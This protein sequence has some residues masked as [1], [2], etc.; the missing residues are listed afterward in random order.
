[1]Q[2][3]WFY[4][5]LNFSRLVRQDHV[6]EDAN[7]SNDQRSPIKRTFAEAKQT[8]ADYEDV[9]GGN[10]YAEDTFLE[11]DEDESYDQQQYP[12]I[13]NYSASDSKVRY[14]EDGDDRPKPPPVNQTVRSAES[15][16]NDTLPEYSHPDESMRYGVDVRKQQQRTR[17]RRSRELFEIDV[18]VTSNEDEL[19]KRKPET[20]RS[21]SED[22]PTRTIKQ[23]VTR[24]TLSHPEKESQ[25]KS[26]SRRPT[27][28][29]SDTWYTY[30]NDL[31]LSLLFRFLDFETNE[32]TTENSESKTIGRHHGT[33][34]T[35]K[36]IENS[37]ATTQ[38]LQIV[39]DSRH[40][41]VVVVVVVR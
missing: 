31:K 12:K 26:P 8:M 32:R 15:F 10:V 14:D 22:T 37:I 33:S 3:I 39:R 20:M 35:W 5:C 7:R 9:S 1:M 21:I 27:Q 24:R 4:F 30:K 19:P 11:A 28:C 41:F 29:C 6:K 17:R 25:V 13:K 18:L 23:P 16:L 2:T 38:K 40:L 34:E 36:T